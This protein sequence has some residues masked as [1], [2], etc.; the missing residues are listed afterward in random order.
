VTK[1]KVFI[2]LT[3][4]PSGDRETALKASLQGLML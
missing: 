1:K 2:T 3:L 4:D